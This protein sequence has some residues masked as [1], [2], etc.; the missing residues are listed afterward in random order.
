MPPTKSTTPSV[1][2]PALDAAQE[3]AL[4]QHEG[5]FLSFGCTADP[6]IRELIRDQWTRE[7]E[8][9]LEDGY[10]EEED[11]DG[12]V[13]RRVA[14]ATH[15]GGVV[16]GQINLALQDGVRVIGFFDNQGV[17]DCFYLSRLND[18]RQVFHVLCIESGMEVGG[19]YDI[20]VS[21]ARDWHAFLDHLP[22]T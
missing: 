20:Y 12:P 5:N 15:A 14:S 13:Q 8:V 11:T 21:P 4:C 6:A 19:P 18:G 10:L 17:G 16:C 22:P 1:A 9:F 2:P 3:Q 7:L